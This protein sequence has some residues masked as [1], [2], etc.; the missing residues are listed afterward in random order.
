NGKVKK[1]YEIDI[2][3]NRVVKLDCISEDKKQRLIK[4][5]NSIDIVWLSEEIER[6]TEALSIAYEKKI[7]RLNNEKI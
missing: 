7:R 1:N 2:P 5:R 4:I 3:I 6:L